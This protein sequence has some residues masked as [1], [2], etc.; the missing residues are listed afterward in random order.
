VLAQDIYDALNEKGY[1]VFFA[2]ISLEDKLGVEY[3]P[4]IFAALNSAKIMLAVGTDYEYYNAVWVKNEWSRYLKLMAQ[5]K[6]KHLIPCYKNIDAYDMPKE[7]AKLQAQDLGKVGAMQDLLRGIEKILPR[8]KNTPVIQERVVVGGAAG[9]K[10][11]A[12]LERGNMAL[13]DGEWAKADSFFE[14]VLSNDARNAQAYLGKVLAQEKCRS[15]DA[16]IRKRL[17]AS[18]S[19]RDEKLVLQPDWAHVEKMAEQYRVPGYLDEEDICALYE[20]DLGYPSQVSGRNQ[21]VT[22]EETYWATHK[23]LTKAEKFAEGAVAQTIAREKKRLFDAL[24]QRVKQADKEEAAAIEEVR[25]RYG[26]FLKKTDGKTC[27]L[28]EEACKD[29]EK[30]YEEVLL[31]AKYSSAPEELDGCVKRFGF[32]GDFRDSKALAE[33]FRKRAEEIREEIR[34]KEIAEKARLA[35]E[36]ERQLIARLK[37]E[38]EAAEKKK[39]ITIFACAA[40]AVALAVFLLVPKGGIPFYRYHQAKSLAEKGKYAEA[41]AAFEALDDYKD[42]SSR[43][44]ECRYLQAEALAAEGKYAEAEAVFATLGDYKDAA[45]RI[46]ECR[47]LQAESLAA[48][49]KYAEAEAAFAALGDYQ[50]APARKKEMNQA[51]LYDQAEALVAEGKYLDAAKKFQELK[52]YSDAA[53]RWEECMEICYRNAES[54]AAEGKKLEAAMAYGAA[55]GYKDAFEKSLTL[56][57]A[58]IKW[59]AIAAGE[60]HIVG[61]KAD[62][63]VVGVGLGRCDVGDWRD[64]VAIAAGSSHTVGLKSDGTVVAV[65]GYGWEGQCNVSDW[66]NI[67]AIATG[68]RHTVGLKADGTVVAVGQNQN[69]QRHVDDWRNIVAIAAGYNHTVGLKADGTVVAVGYYND[70][71]CDVS[72]WTD[73]VAISAGYR[74]TVGLKADGTVV[75]TGDNEDGQCDVS[76][77]SDIVA[78]SAGS[79][80]TV[81]LKADG[82]VVA[83]GF[84]G[85][86]RC[87]V[88]GWRDIVAISA[89]DY[90]TVGLKADGTVVAVGRKCD[91]TGWKGIKVPD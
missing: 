15:L 47:Y 9:N 72:R 38:R 18:Q 65:G 30:E 1:R 8:Q 21:Q 58:I 22:D 59:D 49:G 77:W 60:S 67:V 71:R 90:H 28:H 44:P 51:K 31:I 73:I 52:D 63:T 25:Q 68:V 79:S 62:G 41:A 39:R 75:A 83:V 12:A 36:A 69:G 19:V 40:A 82:T 14:D 78:I 20:F 56:W 54:L 3:E 34:Q 48:E 70:G 80:Y 64:I 24:A 26:D 5:D 76:G 11:A 37:A 43:I 32:L 42:A 86:G 89:G 50:D 87:D 17:D 53:K 81:G 35:E 61:L 4:Y 57:D 91:V 46:P 66:R 84:N 55:G 27:T 23:I 85:N 13:E 16:F 74:H 7:F 2:R 29:R 10:I 88:T 33:H 45:S 6:S